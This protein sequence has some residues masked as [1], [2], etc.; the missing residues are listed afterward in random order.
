MSQFFNSHIEVLVRL[1]SPT[2]LPQWGETRKESWPSS[3]SH[4]ASFQSFFL[5]WLNHSFFCPCSKLFPTWS[6]KHFLLLLSQ[7][8]LSMSQDHKKEEEIVFFLLK[9]IKYQRQVSEREREMS[10]S[11]DP[12]GWDTS[13]EVIR[14][15]SQWFFLSFSLL[16]EK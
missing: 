2:R 6:L 12:A 13:S 11:A 4:R 5:F 16:L 7:V 1:G 15:P 8:N 9:H 3:V 10:S 14:P